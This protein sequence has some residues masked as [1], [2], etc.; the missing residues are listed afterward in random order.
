VDIQGS[1][2]HQIAATA[3]KPRR[4]CAAAF[5]LLGAL[6]AMCAGAWA[7]EV[8]TRSGETLIGTIVEES[9][10]RIVFESKALGR[11]TIPR[12]RILSVSRD[13]A[14][15]PPAQA[16]PAEESFLTR[17][18]PLKGWRTAINVGLIMR[19]GDDSDNDLSLRFRS[20]REAEGG[21]E[22]NLE[23]RYYYAEDV[24]EGGVK[25]ATDDLLSIAY[26]YRRPLSEPW[27]FQSRSSYYRDQVKELDPEVTQT[28]GLG[29]RTDLNG[30]QLTLTPVAG[31][32]WKKV[33]GEE[34]TNAVGGLSQELKHEF[35]KDLTF[36]QSLDYLIALDNAD[37]YSARFAMELNQ[38]L[39]KAW[40]LALRYDY[41]FDAIVGKDASEDQ[42][43]LTL[44]IGLE[45]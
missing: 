1:D 8:R 7:D 3:L 37:D 19:R 40:A 36:G 14:E 12:E 38:K 6:A 28:F 32:Q 42:Q 27:F 18:N 34:F 24:L 26:R 43:R 9:A 29:L 39:G 4:R 30:W 16:A 45:F 17:V 22:H 35:T 33:A 25:V 31:V 15:P 11:I 10:D 21:T 20:T 13:H 41:T 44:S 23:A 5:V 2:E